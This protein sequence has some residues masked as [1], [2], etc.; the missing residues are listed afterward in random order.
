MPRSNAAEASR[1]TCAP[2]FL[3]GLPPLPHRPHRCLPASGQ[4]QRV[5]VTPVASRRCDRRSLALRGISSLGRRE[6]GLPR[7]AG[8]TLRGLAFLLLP[9]ARCP[10]TAVASRSTLAVRRPE[11]KPGRRVEP[12]CCAETRYTIHRRDR[13]DSR[14]GTD[15]SSP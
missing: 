9:A 6:H 5:A 1:V 13:R 12:P 2:S 4:R 10:L 3:R 11:T 14:V 8:L 15:H 7:R